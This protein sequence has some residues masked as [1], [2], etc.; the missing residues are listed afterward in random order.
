MGRGRREP[1]EPGRVRSVAAVVIL[2]I[3]FAWLLLAFL[4]LRDNDGIAG[5]IAI[6]GI[7]AVA[8][9][10]IIQIVFD[11]AVSKKRIDR[12][13]LWWALLVL[14]VGVLGAFVVAVIR[15]PEYF[16]MD[17]PWMLIWIP[18]FVFLGILLGA[19]VWFFFVFPSAMLIRNAV[20]IA[21]GQM[22]ASMLI[23]PSVLLALGVL[24]IAGGLAIDT[25]GI[26]RMAWG[27]II[28]SFLGIPG[29]YE[30][31]WEPGLWIVRGI[32]VAI[33]LVF[34][35]PAVRSRLRSDAED[36]AR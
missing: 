34:L 1:A 9:A 32:V 6:F 29:D 27:A 17:G 19:L 18:I 2:A 26:G 14:P 13:V 7:P 30:I 15:D 8:A 5:T 28:A 11:R 12:A 4:D 21:R 3:A 22:R 33:A 10:I 31:I 16:L 25:D 24:C 20:A 35:I 36:M 23:P